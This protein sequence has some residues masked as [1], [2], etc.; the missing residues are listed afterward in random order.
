LLNRPADAG[1]VTYWV[2]VVR[3]RGDLA[4][5]AFIA[6]SAEYFA[7]AGLRFPPPS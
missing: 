7:K 6:A 1:G 2:P 4:L 5:A 3:I